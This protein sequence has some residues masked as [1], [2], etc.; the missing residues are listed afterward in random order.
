MALSKSNKQRWTLT[1]EELQALQDRRKQGATLKELAFELGVSVPTLNQ[2]FLENGFWRPAT[3]RKEKPSTRPP[4]KRYDKRPK[5][6][7][8]AC[9]GPGCNLQIKVPADECGR[10]LVHFCK[11]CRRRNNDEEWN[12]VEAWG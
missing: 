5:T 12:H 3:E 6:V 10:P 4:R 8:T 7:F 11:A 9:L 2:R 1:L